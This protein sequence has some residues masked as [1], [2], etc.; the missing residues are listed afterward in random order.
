MI[1]VFRCSGAAIAPYL[2]DLARLRIAV[3]RDYP[4]LYEGD[5]AY[6][7]G[8]LS[9]YAASAGSVFVLA[10]DGKRVVGAATGVPLADEASAFQQPF[11]GRGIDPAEVFYFGES[12]L[13]P[14]YRGHGIGHRFF[15]HREARARELG[16]FSFTAFA[17]VDR[18][19]DDPRRPANHRDNDVFWSKRGYVRQPG[20]TMQLAWKELG[21][22]TE[23]EKPLT[24]WLRRL[25]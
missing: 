2:D 6:E 10:C 13:L 17:A 23:T 15:D 4:Y 11:V 1:E 18:S 12:V 19:A 8:Y 14:E 5:A 3:F 7:R 20:M 24:F 16:G 21:E 25:D 9:T 22:E